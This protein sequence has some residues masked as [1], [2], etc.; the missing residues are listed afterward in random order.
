VQFERTGDMA[1]IGSALAFGAA[2]S[3]VLAGVGDE[4]ARRTLVEYV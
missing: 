2:T 1:R 3:R 4:P